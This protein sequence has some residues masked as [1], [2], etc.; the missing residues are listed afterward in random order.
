MR[1]CRRII[2]PERL[3]GGLGTFKLAW[4]NCIDTE[5]LKWVRKEGKSDKYSA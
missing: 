4:R 3:P 2:H 5:M 1:D